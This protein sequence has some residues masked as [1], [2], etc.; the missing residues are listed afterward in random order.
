MPNSYVS[1]AAFIADLSNAP[2]TTDDIVQ[3]GGL[4]YQRDNSANGANIVISDIPNFVP[5]E[6]IQPQ[7]FGA[8]ADGTTDD[9][10]FFSDMFT[11]VM[12]GG[13]NWRE[14]Y[15]P[16]GHYLLNQ[17]FST[18]VDPHNNSD[19]YGLSVRGSGPATVLINNNG[20]GFF[21]WT[22][23]SSND[24]RVFIRNLSIQMAFDGDN[25]NIIEI[26]QAGGGLSRQEDAVLENLWIFP[27]HREDNPTANPPITA[28][29]FNKAISLEGLYWPTI[30]GC[31]IANPFGPGVSTSQQHQGFAGISVV[32]SYCPQVIRTRV[33]GGNY[34]FYFDEV[35][36]TDRFDGPEGGLIWYCVFD[37]NIGAYINADTREPGFEI[38]KTH[39]NCSE[40]GIVMKNRQAVNINDCL[41]YCEEQQNNY[42]DI[43]LENCIDATIKNTQFH[44]VTNP[45]HLAR[46]NIRL[47][48]TCRNIFLEE[49]KHRS[50]GT[51]LSFET[52]SGPL[53]LNR[54]FF[55]SDI[56]S[57]GLDSLPSPL[58]LRIS[59]LAGPRVVLTLPTT[60]TIS[61]NTATDVAWNEVYEEI[62]NW[63]IASLPSTVVTVPAD[64]GIRRVRV[65]AQVRWSSNGTGFREL[66]VTKNTLSVAGTGK[67]T[68]RAIGLTETQVT[69]EFNVQ[70]GDA[71]RL[72]VRQNS[73]ADRTIGIAD[74]WMIVEQI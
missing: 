71:I 34:G 40:A 2:N 48:A 35:D 58:D 49:N 54:P 45:P 52:G 68:N 25:G 67:V 11:W 32:N 66:K 62:G 65:I 31:Q 14:I 36:D 73:N 20:E 7:H 38:T 29:Y 56:T 3:A 53:F 16:A 4:F 13:G 30:V 5:A 44:F 1:R 33:W 70:D 69:G 26:R 51:A 59:P 55:G 21:H 12:G 22:T 9:S 72:V 15:I 50:T 17:A 8:K 23:T 37:S 27:K 39:F 42:T 64:Q 19:L 47:D 10:P 61:H 46:T 28:N 24:I 43:L 18:S 60:Q 57:T 74:T 6:I 41:L 63:G